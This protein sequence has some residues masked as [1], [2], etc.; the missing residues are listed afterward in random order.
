MNKV[1]KIISKIP[2]WPFLGKEEFS[3]IVI[4]FVLLVLV[5]G[6]LNSNFQ[7]RSWER[8]VRY[9]LLKNEIETERELI[10]EITGLVDQRLFAVEQVI[11]AIKDNRRNNMPDLWQGYMETVN[12]WN[13]NDNV[14][15]TRLVQMFGYEVAA[16]FLTDT[17]DKNNVIPLSIHYKFYEI[18]Q[19]LL[20]LKGCVQL[21]CDYQKDLKRIGALIEALS[22]QQSRFLGD[23]NARLISKNNLLKASPSAYMD[24]K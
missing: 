10:S 3:K 9:E 17:D 14:I 11:W 7:E 18:H 20:S 5:G 19:S 23:L 4:S 12:R 1:K 6:Y 22:E 15:Q 16:E 24:T 8:Q 21:G 2:G 13:I